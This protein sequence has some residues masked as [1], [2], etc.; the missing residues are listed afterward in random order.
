MPRQSRTVFAGIPHHIT[1]RGNWREDIFFAN[2]DRE[3]YLTW[4]REYSEKFNVEILAYCLMTNHIHLVAVACAADP[5]PT[6]SKRSL[7]SAALT[8]Q[9]AQVKGVW[10]LKISV[11]VALMRLYFLSVTKTFDL[12]L[13]VMSDWRF[14]RHVA[15]RRRLQRFLESGDD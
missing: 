7:H 14:D 13:G 4:L 9:T 1:Q 2:E 12:A 10:R 5:K 3:S 8:A 6:C 11:I 15:V